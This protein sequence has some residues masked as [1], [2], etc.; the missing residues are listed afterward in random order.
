[1]DDEVEVEVAPDSAK[2]ATPAA[3][4]GVLVTVKAA[5]YAP[6]EVTRLSS[7]ATFL[8]LASP[9]ANKFPKPLPAV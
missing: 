2:V 8:V 3:Q 4:S 1:M 5:L 9:C 7:M 6:P